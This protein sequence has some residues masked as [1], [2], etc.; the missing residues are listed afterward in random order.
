MSET[1]KA[2]P[3]LTAG[4]LAALTGRSAR[5]FQK[6]AKAGKLSF[7]SQPEGPGSA[8]FFDPDGYDEWMAKGKLGDKKW[9]KST[10]ATASPTRGRRSKAWKKD[11]PLRLDLERRLKAVSNSG[12][13]KLALSATPDGS[14]ERPLLPRP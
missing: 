10:G 4:Q 13:R 8:I 5:Y 6:L 2:K 1:I 11:S 3:M 9:R 7:A 12:S 14:S